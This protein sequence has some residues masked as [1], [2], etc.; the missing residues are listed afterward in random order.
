[1]ETVAKKLYVNYKEKVERKE[2][3]KISNNRCFNGI[4]LSYE[5]AIDLIKYW[6]NTIDK[7]GVISV[8]DVKPFLGID[9]TLYTDTLYGW[10]NKIS[11]EKDFEDFKP[12]KNT[13][14]CKLKLQPFKELD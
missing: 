6:N 7:F 12:H 10:T 13:I 1:M 8:Y 11:L 9:D 5:W 14:I 4:I 2:I 3:L